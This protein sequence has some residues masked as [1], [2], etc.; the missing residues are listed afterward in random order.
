MNIV[1]VLNTLFM[2]FWKSVFSSVSWKWRLRHAASAWD[3][4]GERSMPLDRRMRSLDCRMFLYGWRG[5]TVAQ[6]SLTSDVIDHK[7]LKPERTIEWGSQEPDH[8]DTCRRVCITWRWFGVETR[9]NAVHRAFEPSRLH[10]LGFLGRVLRLIVTRIEVVCR[11]M[12]ADWPARRCSSQDDYEWMTA[13]EFQPYPARVIVGRAVVVECDSSKGSSRDWCAKP[14][15]D[16][17]Q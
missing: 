11:H 14:E 7:P 4:L 1:L 15:T 16:L 12:Q 8:V 10:D 13:Q 5:S 9:A 2:Q 3:S 17:S 6:R